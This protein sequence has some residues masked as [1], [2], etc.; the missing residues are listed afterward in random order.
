MPEGSATGDAGKGVRYPCDYGDM[1]CV[2]QIARAPSVTD[3]CSMTGGF[4][5]V[6]AFPAGG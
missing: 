5:G 4:L 1:L 2:V 3:I 6:F